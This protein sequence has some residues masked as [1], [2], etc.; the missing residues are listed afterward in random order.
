MASL[1]LTCEFQVWSVAFLET[2]H[3]KFRCDENAGYIELD[4]PP[5]IELHKGQVDDIKR[6]FMD[7]I[8]SLHRQKEQLVPVPVP[9]PMPGNTKSAMESFEMTPNGFPIFPNVQLDTLKKAQLESLLR[10]YLNQHYSMFLLLIIEF[11]DSH[12]AC[13]W[14]FTTSCTFHKS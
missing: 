9:V 3:L 10:A 2:Q 5:F 14:R 11:S 1:L 13:I 4:A 7:Y 6:R 12:R 8:S